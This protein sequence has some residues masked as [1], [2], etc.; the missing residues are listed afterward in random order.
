[1]E[2][3]ALQFHGKHVRSVFD[4]LGKHENDMTRAMGWAF[5]QCPTLSRSFIEAIVPRQYR[6]QSVSVALQVWQ[7]P[8]GYTDVELTAPGRFH[9][10]FE[11]T[12]GW[13]QPNL[14]QLKKY[15][16][17]LRDTDAKFRS[18]VVLTDWSYVGLKSDLHSVD[19]MPVTWVP[20]SQISSATEAAKRASN[21][22]QRV[23]LDELSRYLGGMVTMQE[24]DTRG[25]FVPVPSKI[26][27]S[28]QKKA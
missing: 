18:L 7:K 21:L 5:S 3:T 25:N 10:R 27:H 15:A 6:A 28:S 9:R 2:P 26:P 1:L 16:A 12:R 22:K 8:K 14:A 11:A 19:G 23:W 13:Q 4:L 24:V 20:W 17:R